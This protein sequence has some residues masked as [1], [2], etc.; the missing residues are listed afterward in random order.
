MHKAIFL[1]VDGVLCLGGQ[2]LEPD[3][4]EN[5]ASLVDEDTHVVI[6]STWRLSNDSLM[7]L[8]RTLTDGGVPANVLA[9]TPNHDHDGGF[10]RA[11]CT[12]IMEWIAFHPEVSEWVILDDEMLMGRLGPVFNDHPIDGHFVHLDPRFGLTKEKAEEA[13]KFLPR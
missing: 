6:T 1:D 4:V 13:K 12:E 9:I 3:L 7:V 2:Q 5:L 8:V 10:H 11:R